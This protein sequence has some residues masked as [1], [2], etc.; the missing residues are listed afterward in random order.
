MYPTCTTIAVS[1][2]FLTRDDS[3]LRQKYGFDDN[4]I[5]AAHTRRVYISGFVF[6]YT[7]YNN[8]HV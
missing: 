6:V 4:N 5:T 1:P 8:T 2:I 3:K 7:M